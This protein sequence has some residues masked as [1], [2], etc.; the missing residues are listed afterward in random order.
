MA[1]KRTSKKK[2]SRKTPNMFKLA[3]QNKAFRAAKKAE[4]KA[5]ARKKAAWRKAL[6]IAKKQVKRKST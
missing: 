3:S 1:K 5:A 2:A 6:A 4:A